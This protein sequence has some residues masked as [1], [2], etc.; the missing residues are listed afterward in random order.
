M[1][2]DSAS[3]CRAAAGRRPGGPARRILLAAAVPVAALLALVLPATWSSQRTGVVGASAAVPSVPHSARAPVNMAW[4][5]SSDH[6]HGSRFFGFLEF[7]WDPDAPG[8]VPGF[9]PWPRP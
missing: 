6:R 2:I 4:S 9:D 8:G 7:D 5:P 3:S 1:D